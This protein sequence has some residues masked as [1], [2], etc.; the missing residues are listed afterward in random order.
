MNKTEQDRETMTKNVRIP[1]DISMKSR[2]RG[3]MVFSRLTNTLF[4]HSFE[5]STE[6]SKIWALIVH[7][8][9]SENC[10][11]SAVLFQLSNSATQTSTQQVLR[12][13]HHPS[14]TRL[15]SIP[16]MF[17]HSPLNIQIF[18]RFIPYFS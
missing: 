10:C 15:L 16:M 1:L 17:H 6:V 18:P 14:L 5:M 2:T 11:E 4:G 12:W 8:S 7:Q 3:G 13:I 9:F